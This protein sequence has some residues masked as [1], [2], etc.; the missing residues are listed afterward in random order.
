MGEFSPYF[1]TA[2][3]M[4][5]APCF[6]SSRVPLAKSTRPPMKAL[7]RSAPWRMAGVRKVSCISMTALAWAT[8][9]TLN[10]PWA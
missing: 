6:L 8:A 2:S 4:R 3:A 1:L 9:L 5:R 10:A 7:A